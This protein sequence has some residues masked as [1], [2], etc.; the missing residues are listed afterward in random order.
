[1]LKVTE[2]VGFFPE[3]FGF[4]QKL[5][6]IQ[7]AAKKGGCTFFLLKNSKKACVDRY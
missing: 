7:M 1:M 2:P 5:R 4:V 6:K 3:H